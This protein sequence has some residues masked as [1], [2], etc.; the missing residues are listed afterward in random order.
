MTKQNDFTSL[1]LKLTRTDR[2]PAALVFDGD[3]TP[4]EPAIAKVYMTD[5]KARRTP[6]SEGNAARLADCWN[7]CLLLTTEELKAAVAHTAAQ[8]LALR[9]IIAAEVKP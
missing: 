4:G 6:E 7:A 9:R 5:A 8:R 2:S 1:P 3:P